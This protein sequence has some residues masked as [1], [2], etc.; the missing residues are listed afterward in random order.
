MLKNIQVTAWS[1]N[2]LLTA[3]LLAIPALIAACFHTSP[4]GGPLTAENE[5]L[6][7]THS[8]PA[9]A[10]MGQPFTVQVTVKVKKSIQAVSVREQLSGLSLVDVG[11]FQ[12][13]D[14]NVLRGF[15]LNPKAGDTQVFT[16]KAQCPAAI[17]YQLVG[18]AETQGA[19]VMETAKIKCDN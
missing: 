16:Y 2:F 19:G 15:V 18:F 17:T 1:R 11:D 4:Q 6:K 13:I 9:T 8:A 10:K 12:G 7:I 14:Q 5:T 3:I